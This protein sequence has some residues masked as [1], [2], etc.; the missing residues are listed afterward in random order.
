MKPKVTVV[1]PTINRGSLIAALDSLDR[2]SFRDF[3]VILVDDSS[4]QSIK[5]DRYKVLKTGGSAGVS[6]SRNLAMQ[7]VDTEF[8]ALLDDDDVWH[9]D[10]L[11]KQIINFINLDIDFAATS[12]IVNKH[13]RPSELLKI[14]MD[15]FELLYGKPHLFKS[16]AYLPTSSYIFR[17]KIASSI[18]F[19]ESILDRE[20][21]KFIRECFV[22]GFKIYQDPEVL[23][24]INY[25]S[26]DSLSRMSLTQEAD[27][28]IYLN[29]LKKDW[30]DNFIIES[31]R[32]FLRSG[33]KKNARILISMINPRK[34]HL[35]K[36]LL[37]LISL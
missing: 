6:K 20:N 26:K 29:K 25:R 7:N 4:E 34:K 5:S 19:D 11:E 37:K 31:A 32:N 1:I 14:G 33:D 15:P 22:S 8:T 21:L 36:T 23:V 16:D 24:T 9:P 12:A 35:F 3:E 2:Q 18:Q 27:W 30:A 17:S 13:K 28:A 10:Y